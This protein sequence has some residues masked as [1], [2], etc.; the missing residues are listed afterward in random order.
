MNEKKELENI[1]RLVGRVTTEQLRYVDSFVG[2]DIGLFMPVGGACFYALTPDH[3]HPSYM[4]TL[5]FDDQ[6]TMKLN[7]STITAQAGKMF[8][9]SP[10]IAHQELFSDS[11]PRY[12]AILID[13]NFFEEQIKHYHVEGKIFLPGEF[14]DS[15]VNLLRLLKRFMIEADNKTAG[16]EAVLRGLSLEICHSIIRSILDIKTRDYRIATRIEID[17]TIEYIHA[18][19]GEKITIEKMAKKACMSPSHFSRIFKQETGTT[20]MAYLNRMRMER[21]KKLLLAGDKSIT[22]I[23]LECGLNSPAYLSAAFFKKF[24]ITPSDFRKDLNK[25]SI[26]K[27]IS[28]ISKG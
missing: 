10:G 27:K 3:S 8:A 1:R 7:N 20:P 19:L 2:D 17:K 12:I 22:E 25:S 23:A 13:R 5:H 4:F 18:F 26:S 9:L 24:K 16:S 11:P 21:T 14:Y 15:N 28:R 6:T